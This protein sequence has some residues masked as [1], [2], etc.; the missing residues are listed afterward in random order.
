MKIEIINLEGIHNREIK[1]LEAIAKVFPKEWLAYASL[2]LLREQRGSREFDLVIVTFDRILA[3]EIKDWNGELKSNGNE[4]VVN[5]KSRGKSPVLVIDKKAKI[6]LSELKRISKVKDLN[7]VPVEGLVV[8]TGSS[9]KQHLESKEKKSVFSLNE[10]LELHKDNHYRKIFQNIINRNLCENKDTFNQ[11]FS[12]KHFF[13]PQEQT[14]QNH[15]IVGEPIYTHPTQLYSEY[16][17]QDIIS[18]TKALLRL[19]ELYRLPIDQNTQEARREIVEREA[20]VLAHL[21]QVQSKLFENRV[22]VEQKSYEATDIIAEKYVEIY[23]LPINQDRLSQFVHKTHLT[24]EERISLI[25]FMLSHFADIHEVNIAHRD[26]GIDCIWANPSKV[27][28]SGFMSATLPNANT[29]RERLDILRSNRNQLPEHALD[30]SGTDPFRQDVFSLGVASHIIAFSEL[31][32]QDEGIPQWHKKETFQQY[33]SWFETAL[34]WEP[35][36]RYANARE[37]SDAFNDIS[38]NEPERIDVSS[39]IGRY[40]TSEVVMIKYTSTEQLKYPPPALVYK[41]STNNVPVLVKSWSV[42]NIGEITQGLELYNFLQSVEKLS[43]IRC[44]FLSKFLEYGI[45]LTNQIFIVQQYY[46]GKTLQQLDKSVTLEQRVQ[47][48]LKLIKAVQTLHENEIYH[49]DIR[50]ENIIIM[51]DKE[52]LYPVLIDIIEYGQR[53][54]CQNYNPPDY[55]QL[56]LAERD[57]YAAALVIMELLNIKYQLSNGTVQIHKG[58]P[59]KLNG[60]YK[61]LKEMILPNKSSRL[62]VFGS[63]IDELE[64]IINPPV[65][66]TS[67]KIRLTKLELSS[68]IV[69]DS[70]YSSGKFNNMVSENGVYYIKY[71]NHNALN[72]GKIFIKGFNQELEI[73]FNRLKQSIEKCRVNYVDFENVIRASRND[74]PIRGSIE[75]EFSD[76]LDVAELQKFIIDKILPNIK[77]QDSLQEDHIE[78]YDDFI[79]SDRIIQE[80]E[81]IEPNTAER[82]QALIEVEE[83][84]TVEVIIGEPI[85]RD[86]DQLLVIP[87]DCKN[88]TP[89]FNENDI[90]EVKYKDKRGED[91]ILGNLDLRR[92]NTET[93]YIQA[94]NLPLNLKDISVLTL[95]S[96]WQD[97]SFNRRSNA[98]KRI[99][100]RQSVIDNL[101]DIFNGKTEGTI[102]KQRTEFDEQLIDKYFGDN[103]SQKDAFK[104]ILSHSPVGLL[105]GPPGTGK[106]KFI[107]A[108]VHYLFNKL[109]VKNILLV[110]QSHEAVNNLAEAINKLYLEIDPESNINMVRIGAEGIISKPL[111]KYHSAGLRDKYRN[112]FKADFKKK[113]KQMGSELGLPPGFVSTYFE[114]TQSLGDLIDEIRQTKKIDNKD[115]HKITKQKLGSLTETFYQIYEKKYQDKF[116]KADDDP[117]KTLELLYGK[118]KEKCNVLS[119]PNFV[120]K[121]EKLI[122]LGEEWMKVLDSNMSGFEEFLARTRPIIVGTCV[123]VGKPSLKIDKNVYDWVIIDEAARCNPSELAVSMQVGK[124]VLLVGDHKQLPPMF[125]ENVLEETAKKLGFDKEKLKKSEFQRL[126]E[127]TLGKEIGYGLDRQYRMCQ[128]IANMISDVFYKDDGIELKTM[129]TGNPDFYKHIPEMLA[130]QVTWIDTS[131]GEKEAYHKEGNTK[132]LY[133]PYEADT[134]IKLL[135]ILSE[136]G[137]FLAELKKSVVDEPPIGI[138]CPYSAQKDHILHEIEKKAWHSDFRKLLKV[139]T[140]DSYQ[141]KENQIIIVS[142]TRNDPKLQ[143]GFLKYPE[144]IN[145]SLSRARERL[146]I[147]GASR[148]WEVRPLEMPLRRVL[149]YIER[150]KESAEYGLI[151]SNNLF[152]SQGGISL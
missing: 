19:W 80:K 31:P 57:V 146:V 12:N 27:S 87:Y 40:K 99:I 115:S 109:N 59:D 33:D 92:T 25:K 89:D 94:K 117:D 126:M 111:L 131:C 127:S 122:L 149:A 142:L 120:K 70:I 1:G 90:V 151:N 22:I 123:G 30:I 144:R 10:F 49:R 128:P 114:I 82:W 147:I 148:M 13:K 37:M 101:I 141:G 107:A 96:L 150:L 48:A 73:R 35:S 86:K 113:I 79:S 34:S 23:D 44:D 97:S 3:V 125:D 138:I 5:G 140:V 137:F 136:S 55:K 38:G 77:P 68:E 67:I 110:S 103:E 36:A 16:E 53:D 116:G 42:Q 91:R 81:G 28:F 54:Y 121:L 152:D 139:D 133:N 29:I 32:T 129:R 4:W 52:G 11:F 143:T 2:E 106:T 71:E 45:D 6:L 98:T 66:E 78:E 21:K 63:L 62:A 100:N 39:L 130:K 74:S 24:S 60:I 46:E 15:K 14:Y 47:I 76:I 112:S 118:L 26:L 124:K 93:L 72:P 132:S 85:Y 135:D 95:K 18:N 102:Y 56:S 8:L 84:L 43:R 58:F 51:T 17:A 104:K 61:I 41:S 145:V 7:Q 88:I 119:Y 9:D 50:P 20:R 69:S 134:I 75:I 105:Q 83:N 108:V 64:K 65:V